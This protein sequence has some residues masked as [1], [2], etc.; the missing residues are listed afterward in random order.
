ML[1]ELGHTAEKVNFWCNYNIDKSHYGIKLTT[2][3]C[4]FCPPNEV[5]FDLNE[6]TRQLRCLRSRLGFEFV[7]I[8]AAKF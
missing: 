5:Y 3:V 6:L 8:C 7:R 1:L 4:L 2:E